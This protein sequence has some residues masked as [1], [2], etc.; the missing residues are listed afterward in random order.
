MHDAKSS[1]WE[2]SAQSSR[3]WFTLSDPA[4]EEALHDVPL[5][6]EFA[7]LGGWSDRLPDESTILLFRHLLEKHKLAEQILAIVNDML[8]GKGLL[9][10]AGTV[11]DATLIAAPRSIK[12]ASGERDCEMH[13]SKKGNPW[14]LG[15]KA[16]IGVDAESCL[17]HTVRGTSGNVNDVVEANA[18][19]HGEETDAF[20]NAGYQGAAK[21]PDAKKGVAWHTAMRPGRRKALDLSSPLAAMVDKLEKIKASIRA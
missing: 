5:F 6:R 12:N 7:G 8:I 19:L 3:Q 14:Y 10:K 4:A 11:V 18:L 2:R 20:G 13:Q 21:R 15:M 1:G 17:V 9:R 16:D